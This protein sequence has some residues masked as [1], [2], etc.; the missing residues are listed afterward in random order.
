MPEHNGADQEPE[1][2]DGDQHKDIAGIIAGVQINN[3]PEP[4]HPKGALEL[5]SVPVGHEIR[6]SGFPGIDG[7]PQVTG[8]DFPLT[9]VHDAELA[10]GDLR[11]LLP[12]LRQG[13]INVKMVKKNKAAGQAAQQQRNRTQRD[14]FCRFSHLAFVPSFRFSCPT[15]PE[16]P[17]VVIRF[18]PNRHFQ[19]LQFCGTVVSAQILRRNIMRKIEKENP[20][21]KKLISLVLILCMACMLVPAM[22]D[23]SLLGTWYLKE[24]VS[25][26]MTLSAASMG[27]SMTFE[28][29]DGGSVDL[30]TAYGEESETQS[31]TW[32]QEGSV[33]TVTI[34]GQAAPLTL[35]DETLTLE[36]ESGKMVFTREVPEAAPATVFVDAENEEAFFGTWVLSS[37][38][39]MGQQVPASLLSTFGMDLTV[40]LTIEAGKAT[41]TFAYNGESK[42]VAIETSF[43]DGKLSMIQEGTELAPLA[44]T[45]GG[46]LAFVLPIGEQSFNLFLAPAETAEEPAA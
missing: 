22:A 36:Q 40:S 24:A 26:E 33:V 42:E 9:Q 37:L 2:G 29:K 46:E 38:E 12:V 4:V 21:M 41:L 10:E 6:V 43:A 45:E 20:N 35:A 15:I 13:N 5:P 8:T 28:F 32:T 34:D 27:M 39:I 3:R 1:Y 19:K 44:L 25:G 23:D 11:L 18:F 30:I 17:R 7:H 31:G 16:P 14:L